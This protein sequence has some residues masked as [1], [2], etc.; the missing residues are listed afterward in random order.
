M[1]FSCI[2]GQL[3]CSMNEPQNNSKPVQPSLITSLAVCPRCQGTG[4][5]PR[6]QHIQAGRCFRCQGSGQQ[7]ALSQAASPAART[8]HVA[9]APLGITL[10]EA[11]LTALS[12]AGRPL[13]TC[14]ALPDVNL[15]LAKLCKGRLTPSQW[16][17]LT[18]AY[19]GVTT[20]VALEAYLKHVGPWTRAELLDLHDRGYFL[21]TD[22][23]PGKP[24]TLHNIVVTE[25]FTDL[26]HGIE[27]D[28]LYA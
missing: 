9:P 18:F 19:L 20:Q 26:Y 28:L 8:V 25:R 12:A 23:D 10:P 3:V 6:Y 16:L 21:R 2:S 7:L 1:Q 15:P 14:A 22:R 11:Q 17:F 27:V 5:L 13:A 4:H 24:L